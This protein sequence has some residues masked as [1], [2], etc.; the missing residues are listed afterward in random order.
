[1][2]SIIKSEQAGKDLVPVFWDA[3]K[4]LTKEE[5][6]IRTKALEAL[7]KL[8]ESLSQVQQEEMAVGLITIWEDSSK[9]WRQRELFAGYLGDLAGL[10]GSRT[11]VVRDL[12]DRALRDEIAAVRN[13]AIGTV[14]TSEP[15]FFEI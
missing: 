11:D 2:A 12:M 4:G 5:E 6:D 14:S 10:V 15:H 3:V 7:P 1:M 9:Y 13:A 8:L